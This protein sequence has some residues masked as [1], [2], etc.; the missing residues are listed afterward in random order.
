MSAPSIAII[1][2]ITVLVCLHIWSNRQG[3]ILRK[4]LDANRKSNDNLAQQLKIFIAIQ[5]AT[6]SKDGGRS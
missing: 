3:E 6:R 1:T 5:E 2:C 4:A